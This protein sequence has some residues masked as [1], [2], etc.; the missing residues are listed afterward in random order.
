MKN[1]KK[2]LKK[3]PISKI[4][5]LVI[6]F[7]LLWI[8][9]ATDFLYYTSYTIDYLLNRSKYT[10]KEEGQFKDNEFIVDDSFL[11]RYMKT[12]REKKLSELPLINAQPLPE[13]SIDNLNKDTVFKISKGFT[14]P[15]VVR[16]LIRDFDCVKKWDLDYFE[17]EYGNIEMLSFSDNKSVSYSNGKSTKLKSCNSEN[18]LCT[19]KEIIKGIREGEPVYVNNISKL[20]TQSLQAR[21]ELNLDKM[22]NIMNTQMFQQP[23]DNINF[24]SQLFFG[25]KNTGTNLHCA[26]NINFFFNIKGKKHWAF[27]DPKYT[28][29]IKCQTSNQALFSISEDDYFS[30]SIDNPFL[31]IPRYESILEP[32][33]FLF[34]PA[35]YWHAVKNKT[36]YTIAVANRFLFTLGGELPVIQN[37]LFFSF[38]QLFS[39]LYY[40][41]WFIKGKDTTD[42]QTTFGEMVD[43]EI[44][45]NLSNSKAM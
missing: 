33:D 18:N 32:G 6:L 45:N 24:M 12:V 5:Y 42:S 1:L 21:K 39:P 15:F 31:K 35:W 44:I 28:D 11:S 25:G 23:Q 16:G 37:N 9:L 13:I 40:L 10:F 2:I 3:I 41:K 8:I 22:G 38:L 36:D 34:N 4:F 43:Q 26:S 7:I 14:Q 30:E 20:F 27:I 29:L 19:L 17:K